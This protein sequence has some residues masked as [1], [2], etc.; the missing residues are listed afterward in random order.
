MDGMSP[1]LKATTGVDALTHAVGGSI[2]RRAWALTDALHIKAIEIIAGALR[3][4]V[5]G[6][7]AAGE[8]MALGKF[9]EG[10]GSWDVGF[11]LVHG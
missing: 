7:E 6:D 2:T 1:A 5:A 11:G 10:M 3:G 4:S 8:E 9:V